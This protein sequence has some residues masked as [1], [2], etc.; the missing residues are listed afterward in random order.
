MKRHIFLSSALK[1]SG[2]ARLRIRE[3]VGEAVKIR[4]AG[5]DAYRPVW[6]AEDFPAFEPAS[7]LP[8]LE[9]V[10][11]CLD[12][13]REAE[14]FVAVITGRHGSEVSV[15]GVGDVPTT[16]LE[17]ELFEAAV[18][19]KPAFVFVLE[20]HEPEPRLDSLL[21]VLEPFFPDINRRPV[22]EGEIV[23]QIE[24]L[25]R[26]YDRPKWLRPFQMPP[27]LRQTVRALAALRHRPYDVQAGMPSLR[28]LKH[29][30]DPNLPPPDPY[31]VELLL[32]RADT[33]T[34]QQARLTILWFAI[35]EL[36]G[37]PFTDPRFSAFTP[38]WDRALS[39]WRSAG[40]W[41]GLHAHIELGCLAAL[42]SVCEIRKNTGKEPLP[43]GALASE[44]YSIAGLMRSQEMLAVSLRHVEE[45]I[46]LAGP[47]PANA[48]TIRGSI[49][50]RMGHLT[51]AIAD[52]NFVAESKREEGGA[53]YG[54][55]LSELGFAETLNR[56][57]KKGISHMEEGLELL[58][59]QP[60]DGFTIRAMRKLAYG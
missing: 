33:T 35:R 19:G 52:Y 28:F 37:A 3:L 26:Y 12:G 56:N 58:K 16:Y 41:Y 45:A 40:A 59:Q 31:K 17:A 4:G 38:L 53:A 24:S 6:M 32:E 48:I 8:A 5:A 47:N 54:G 25:V 51:A 30:H 10:Q 57:L 29:P 50:R 11:L 15:D 36:T 23:R 49:Y 43:H 2:D 7:S 44:Y 60:A 14:C 42:G 39:A 9:K 21:K 27:K 34:A 1:D 55:A 22:S 46:V 18:L 13:V 20:G